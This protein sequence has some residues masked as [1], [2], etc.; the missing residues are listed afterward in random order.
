MVEHDEKDAKA[1]REHG[2][3]LA[4]I[5]SGQDDG[6]EKEIKKGKLIIY[7]KSDGND[8]E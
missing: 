3:L 6:E 8:A 4:K 2:L 5:V 1:G 7:K